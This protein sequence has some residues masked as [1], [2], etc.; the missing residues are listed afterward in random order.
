M[1]NTADIIDRLSKKP[2]AAFNACI[3]LDGFVDRII[4]VVD[5]RRSAGECSYVRT[6]AD[7]GRLISDASGFSLNVE[8]I[9]EKSQLGGN[10]P[11]MAYALAR[12]GRDVS[13]IGAFGL[14]RPAA[15][16]EKLEKL[17]RLYSLSEPARTDDYEFDD[18]KI[19]ASTLNSLNAL[20]WNA[21]TEKLPPEQI[22]ALF[23]EAD[24]IALNNW[25][26]IPAMTGIWKRIQSDTLPS[27]SDKERLY[28]IDMA[29]PGKRTDA[30][31]AEALRAMAGF[32]RFGRTVLSCN[33]REAIQLAGALELSASPDSCAAL[34][35]GIRESLGIW[36]VSLHT[37]T[38]SFA[39]TASGVTEAP[40]FYTPKPR[41][42]IGG[43]DHFNAGLVFALM[44]GFTLEEALYVASAVSGAYVRTGVTPTLTDLVRFISE[45]IENS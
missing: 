38:G 18:G 4:R 13:C 10:G 21:I 31:V 45:N 29:D 36:C 15:E 17:A 40:G 3:G 44:D 14:P 39:A 42:S 33:H 30:D 20:D 1:I 2:Y 22:C 28:F 7:Y 8:L 25:T 6:L 19:I 9:C 26:M 11:I 16:F 24:V 5:K 12:L 23:D 34:A 32:E 43:G 35:D 41:V 37:L 27:L